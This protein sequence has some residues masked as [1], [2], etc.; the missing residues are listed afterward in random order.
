VA[1]FD[2]SVNAAAHRLSSYAF[3]SAA[4]AHAVVNFIAAPEM[5][6]RKMF[7][8]IMD[9]EGAFIERDTTGP[10]NSPN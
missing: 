8:V 10:A 9:I 2:D 3:N 4:V 1:S 6:T 5:F 7:P